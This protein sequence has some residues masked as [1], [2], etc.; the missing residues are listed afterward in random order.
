MVYDGTVHTGV[1]VTNISIK[2]NESYSFTFGT[3]EGH[4][5]AGQIT[6]AASQDKNGNVSFGIISNSRSS[7]FFTDKAY[8]FLGGQSEQT[9]HWETFLKNL[10][11]ITGSNASKI[12]ETTN[13]SSTPI[14]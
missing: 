6:F 9:A 11:K 8:R 2:A 10:I 14:N 4:V 13:K 5:E 1:T 3:W 12:N 7:G